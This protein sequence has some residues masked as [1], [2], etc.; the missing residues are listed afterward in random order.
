[1]HVRDVE[2][3]ARSRRN[4]GRARMHE[5]ASSHCM[6]LVYLLHKVTVQRSQSIEPDE[7]LDVDEVAARLAVRRA[8]VYRLIRE[9]EV[10]AVRIGRL[11]RVRSDS[12]ASFIAGG[13]SPGR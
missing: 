6:H 3:D 7:L 5:D 9:G 1:M 13:G 11:W 8:S 4:G 10:A 2:A 12:L